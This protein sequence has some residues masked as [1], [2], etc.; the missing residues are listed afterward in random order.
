MADP[1]TGSALLMLLRTDIVGAQYIIDTPYT[2]YDY[3]QIVITTSHTPIVLRQTA[4]EDSD[5]G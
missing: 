1:T 2:A 4:S 5:N 3:A